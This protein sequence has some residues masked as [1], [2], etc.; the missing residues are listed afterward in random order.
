MNLYVVIAAACVAGV[1]AVG[2]VAAFAPINQGVWPWRSVPPPP[3]PFAAFGPDCQIAPVNADHLFLSAPVYQGDTLTNVQLGDESSVTT[4]VRVFVA[5]GSKPITVLLQSSQPVIW[6]FEGA[7]GRVARAMIVPGYRD[8]AAVAGLSAAQVDL[9]KLTRCP[10][11]I[12]PFEQAIPWRRDGILH[13]LF[14][15]S[16]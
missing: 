13:T 8:R 1:L 7:V 4:M 6:N 10:E 9:V 2:T 15:R 5:P 3:P 14:G 12:V 16:S 11:R